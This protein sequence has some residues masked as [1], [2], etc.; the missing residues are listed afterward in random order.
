MSKIH[1][2]IVPYSGQGSILGLEAI[3]MSNRYFPIHLLPEVRTQGHQ[4]GDCP[5]A[6]K[7]WFEQHINLPI[8]PAMTTE[9]IDHL[10]AAVDRTIRKVRGS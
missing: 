1:K 5:I 6:E 3:G 10:I 8:Y 7:A 2:M 4:L 9:Q